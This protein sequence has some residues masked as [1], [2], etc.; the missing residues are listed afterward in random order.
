MIANVTKI[1]IY[2][3]QFLI[4]NSLYILFNFCQKSKHNVY[5]LCIPWLQT[6]TVNG[7]LFLFLNLI[8]GFFFFFYAILI[9]YLNVI[10]LTGAVI[11][12]IMGV[13]GAGKT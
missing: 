13:S 1:I 3:V 2:P 12:V 6:T 4:L 7:L 10:V 9:N 8:L 11:V 5:N